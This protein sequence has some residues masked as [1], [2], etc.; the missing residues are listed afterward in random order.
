[1]VDFKV[2]YL[3][4]KDPSEKYR[5]RSYYGHIYENVEFSNAFRYLKKRKEEIV[6]F[7]I[8]FIH[9]DKKNKQDYRN[10]KVFLNKNFTGFQVVTIDFDIKGNVTNKL[11]KTNDNCNYKIIIGKTRS[12]RIGYWVRNYSE[13]NALLEHP[14]AFLKSIEIRLIL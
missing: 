3:K 13:F 4:P 14:E 5:S 9:D 10:A 2:L 6:K 8:F 1:M 11:M 12:S 7:T